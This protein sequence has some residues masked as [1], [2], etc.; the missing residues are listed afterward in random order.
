MPFSLKKSPKLIST[1][2]R[3][4]WYLFLSDINEDFCYTA[5]VSFPGYLSQNS[6]LFSCL[7]WSLHSSFFLALESPYP[8]PIRLD[9]LEMWLSALFRPL[10]HFSEILWISAELSPQPILSYWFWGSSPAIPKRNQQLS[11]GSRLYYFSLKG[12]VQ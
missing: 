9:M 8:N 4:S 2:L 7:S 1:S 5:E 11:F 6:L 10:W 3:S 12:E